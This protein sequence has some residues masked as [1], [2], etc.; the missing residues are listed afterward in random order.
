MVAR[1]LFFG[2]PGKIQVLFDLLP[3]G[4]ERGAERQHTTIFRLVALAAIRG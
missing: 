3:N 4:R 2:S 1:T